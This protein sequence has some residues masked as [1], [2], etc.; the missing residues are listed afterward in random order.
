[1]TWELYEVWAA[2]EDG[3]E[4]LINTTKSHKEAKQLAKRA[5]GEGSFEAWICRETGDGDYEEI[6]RF[7]ID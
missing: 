1:M 6:E 4:Q 3:H 7:E 5:L 2:D